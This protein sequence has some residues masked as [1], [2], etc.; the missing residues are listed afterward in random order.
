[1]VLLIYAIIRLWIEYRIKTATAAAPVSAGLVSL[2]KGIIGTNT[3]TTYIL[4][5]AGAFLTF[6]DKL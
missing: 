1:M 6:K 3:T 2:D 4:L 5:A